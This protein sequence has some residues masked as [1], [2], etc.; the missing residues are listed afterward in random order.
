MSFFLGGVQAIV[1]ELDDYNSAWE[2]CK[3]EGGVWGGR[4][5]GGRGIQSSMYTGNT[6]D[7]AVSQVTIAFDGKVL[8]NETKLIIA[9]GHRY[10]MVGN[11]GVGKT[12]LLRRI[13]LEAVPGSVALFR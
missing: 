12:T 13:A 8:L 5:R 6:E 11:N 10:G 4:A 3:R 7:V 1:N 2:Q 9:H